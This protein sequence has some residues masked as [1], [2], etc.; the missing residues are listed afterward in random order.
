MSQ[1]PTAGI[2][3]GPYRLTTDASDAGDLVVF[4][5]QAEER[6]AAVLRDAGHGVTQVQDEQRQR[7]ELAA[8]LEVVSR[9]VLAVTGELALDTVLRRLVDLAR[10][11]S[12]ARY[13]AL[14]VP[15]PRG[16]LVAFLTSGMSEEEEARIG[17]RPRGGGVLG[18]LLREPKTIRITDLNAHPAAVGF[19][20]Q[21]PPMRSFLGVPIIARG[22]VLGNFYL[23]E[24]RTA[25]EFSDGDT[26]VVELLARHAGVAIENARLYTALGEQQRRLQLLVDQM[27]EAVLIAETGP[28]RI[29]M[30]NPQ[31]Y[32]AAGVAD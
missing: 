18:L 28:E 27:P 30:A 3:L 19:P 5:A 26:R 24:K 16:D 1:H 8:Q 21:H 23:T 29:T 11:L 2:A 12:G 7:L 10:E 20:P 4:D 22:R 31:A 14:G 32:R 25:S 9:A 6:A 15:G 13:A 17:P